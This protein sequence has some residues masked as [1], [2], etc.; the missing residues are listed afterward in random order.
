MRCL[1][2]TDYEQQVMDEM[3]R[4]AVARGETATVFQTADRRMD[5]AR[6]RVHMEA[7]WHE[8]V[9]RLYVNGVASD[10]EQSR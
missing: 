1:T 7:L 10:G 8:A 4:L 9:E 5:T 2:F 3:S 6:L